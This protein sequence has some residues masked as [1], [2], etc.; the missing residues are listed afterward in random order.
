MINV[1][2]GA[3]VASAQAPLDA[4]YIAFPALIFVVFRL[5]LAKNMWGAFQAGLWV[6]AGYFGCYFNW[7]IFPFLVDAST[8]GWIAPFALILMAF[9][10]GILWGFAS[11]GAYFFPNR[12]WGIAVGLSLSELIRGYILTGFPWGMIGHMWQKTPLIQ[13]ISFW[14]VTGLTVMTVF[15][16]MVPLVWGRRGVLFL[17]LLGGALCFYGWQRVDIQTTNQAEQIENA[18]STPS[19]QRPLLRLVQP[20]VVQHMKW[21]A[22]EAEKNFIQ[23][24]DMTAS[25]NGPA[26]LTIW[27][28]TSIAYTVEKTPQLTQ[29]ISAASGGEKVALGIQRIKGS[30]GWNSLRVIEKNGVVSDSYDKFHLVPFGEYTPLGDVLY[31]YLGISAFASQVGEGYSAGSGPAVLDLGPALGKVQPLICYEALFPDILRLAPL[32]PEWILQITNDAWFGSFTGPFQHFEQSR[33]RAIE[34]GLPLVRVANTGITAVIDAYGN[35][36]SELPFEKADVLDVYEIPPALPPT[37]Y[38]RW[39]DW[40]ALCLILAI[41]MLSLRYGMRDIA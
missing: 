16:A 24:L 20:N 33:L 13:S 22:A 26:L 39:G 38:T 11:M 5:S 1:G 27:P 37:F 10:F 19:N 14:G 17:A 31:K 32:R 12:L 18:I 40:V 7:I 35:V 34:F 21:N 41:I 6:G 29:Y 2:A 36:I 3:L 15:G 30:Q 9:G 23:L 8:Y 4:W 28:E 25:E